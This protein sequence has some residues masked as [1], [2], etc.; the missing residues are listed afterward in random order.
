MA[1][2]PAAYLTNPPRNTIGG[3]L[4]ENIPVEERRPPVLNR[5]AMAPRPLPPTMMVV[6]PEGGEP[7]EHLRFNARDLIRLH[8][9][10]EHRV[11]KENADEDNEGPSDGVPDDTATGVRADREGNPALQE[12]DALRTELSS[13][14]VDVDLRWGTR[15][16]REML[17][18][19]KSR[20]A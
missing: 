10:T 16:L 11:A 19:V 6:P 14:G 4:P 13:L 17:E 20:S 9:W 5:S 12:L 15:R 7:V 18:A 1:V 3:P 8:G 2:A